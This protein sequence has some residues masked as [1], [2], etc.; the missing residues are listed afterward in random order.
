M[1]EK[2]TNTLGDK[3]SKENL[4]YCF[5]RRWNII[6]RHVYFMIFIVH[7]RYRELYKNINLTT[8]G[9]AEFFYSSPEYPLLTEFSNRL[10]ESHP[11]VLLV[12][13]EEISVFNQKQSFY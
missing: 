12:G 6:E 11:C 8:L 7:I 1:F 9:V 13:H 5:F 4:V 10:I 2:V 3:I